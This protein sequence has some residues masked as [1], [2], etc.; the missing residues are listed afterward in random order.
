M[1][2]LQSELTRRKRKRIQREIVGYSRSA[3][4]GILGELNRIYG[5][6]SAV[7]P[8]VLFGRR[9]QFARISHQT[10]G[11]AAA[12][13]DRSSEQLNM[14]SVWSRSGG[15]MEGAAAADR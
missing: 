5:P 10:K 11:L 1:V 4:R 7:V 13:P 3:K 2:F 14:R 8:K 9:A 15:I 12:H 6:D